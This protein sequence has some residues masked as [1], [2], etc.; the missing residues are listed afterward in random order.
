MTTPA[1]HHARPGC[2]VVIGHDRHDHTDYLVGHYISLSRAKKAARNR[3]RRA[4]A[5]PTSLSDV[6]FVYDD[7]G[8]CRYR[9]CFDDLQAALQQPAAS[10]EMPEAL[11]PPRKNHDRLFIKILL[12]LLL[13]P[14]IWLGKD[15]YDDME[16]TDKAGYAEMVKRFRM[17]RPIDYPRHCDSM[18]WDYYEL[19]KQYYEDERQPRPPRPK[20]DYLRDKLRYYEAT[21][22]E[23]PKEH[24]LLIAYA[25]EELAHA[26]PGETMA[27]DA[28]Y[29]RNKRQ[30][31]ANREKYLPMYE[32]LGRFVAGWSN[33]PA[34]TVTNWDYRRL[35]R[36]LALC[37]QVANH[38]WVPSLTF[39][40]SIGDE[41]PLD[42]YEAGA[43]MRMIEQ[44]LARKDIEQAQ[45]LY[46]ALIRY[47]VMNWAV[48][49]DDVQDS[50]SRYS[51]I[52]DDH[53]MDK[54]AQAEALASALA[55][56]N[57]YD[58]SQEYKA[59]LERTLHFIKTT[60]ATDALR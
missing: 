35:K 19:I 28:L 50:I 5:D 20:A 10:V 46:L 17:A 38:G 41:A 40:F 12:L 48:Y 47:Q 37:E 43:F 44:A 33:D 60:M 29:E 53:R 58:F 22:F 9:V 32:E 6:F 8:E 24:A 25:Q 51:R 27:P 23:G 15:Y 31:L 55:P 56:L 2:Y 13:V 26:R 4:N 7:A 30:Y 39:H 59:Y 57:P 45:A 1:Q 52:L 42:G 16:I 11:P 54:P 21:A 3:A 49:F 14:L 36:A 34:L 18:D